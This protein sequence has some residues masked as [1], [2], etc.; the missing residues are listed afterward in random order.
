MCSPDDDRVSGNRRRGMQTNLAGDKV[1]RLIVV[2]LQI[3]DATGAEARDRI[4]GFCV[5]CDEAVARRHVENPFFAAVGPVREAATRELPGR[6][7]AALTFALAV[8]P[9]QLAG[10]RV[11]CDDGPPRASG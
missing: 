7:R 9:Q 3:D 1:D 4:A 10:G 2:Q 11:E 8:H 5:E 6:S